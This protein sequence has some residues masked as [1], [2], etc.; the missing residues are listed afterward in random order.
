M[1]KQKSIETLQFFVT[2]LSN[3]AFTHLVQ[4]HV[5]KSQGY[6]KLADKFA[7]HSKEEY[8]WVDKFIDRILDLG[9]CV[10][11]EQRKAVDIVCDPV[12]YM[13][14]ELETQRNGVELLSKCMAGVSGDVTTYD[15]LKDYYKDEEGDLY[16][17]ETQVDLIK[18]LGD[19][20]WL[21]TQL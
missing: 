1:D 4:S 2:E 6:N 17:D 20:N 18:K 19:A 3:G 16:D 5:F 9:G 8:A 15:L 11:V 12:E 10:K 13:S 21:L 14:A 7:D